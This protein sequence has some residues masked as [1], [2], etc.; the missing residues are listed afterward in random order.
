MTVLD[1]GCGSGRVSSALGK[2]V[3][4]HGFIGIDIIQELLQYAKEKSPNHYEFI[5]SPSLQI[6][7]KNDCFDFAYAFSV[8]THLLQ[9]E[10]Y[11]YKMQ[12]FEKL[13]PG[14]TFVYSFLEIDK[15]W[16][17]FKNGTS[18]HLR[19]GKPTPHLDMFL[20]RSQIETMCAHI[21]FKIRDYIEPTGQKSSV[22]Q[23]AIILQKPVEDNLNS[24]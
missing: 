19:H 4:L 16:D 24:E 22:A 9:S 2:L 3:D 21:G 15:H 17:V 1:F 10:I 5:V 18:M 7:I 6:P 20:E 12:I 8:F 13:R 14:G 11:I 23:A